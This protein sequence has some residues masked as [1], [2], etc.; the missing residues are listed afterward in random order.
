MA[1][2]C[3]FDKEDVVLFVKATLIDH[4]PRHRLHRALRHEVARPAVA[5]KNRDQRIPA[6]ESKREPTPRTKTPF[7]IMK[8][9]LGSGRR[10]PWCSSR[11]KP[12]CMV[13]IIS[14]NWIGSAPMALH[15]GG[16]RWIHQDLRLRKKRRKAK[17]KSCPVLGFSPLFPQTLQAHACHASP[18][19]SAMRTLLAPD[20]I[21]PAFVAPGRSVRPTVCIDLPEKIDPSLASLATFHYG[22]P[23]KSSS[24]TH[25]P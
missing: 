2:E 17:D 21:D 7:H 8:R 13:L 22:K 14:L 25:E 4:K 16:Q 19:S 10:L 18:V 11:T 12:P 24:S 23:T 9:R 3:G 20:S 5:T 6:L 1:N 15:T